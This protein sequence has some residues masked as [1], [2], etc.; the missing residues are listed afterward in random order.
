VNAKLALSMALLVCFE[1]ALGEQKEYDGSQFHSDLSSESGAYSDG[2]TLGFING[3]SS[4]GSG[5]LW[6]FPGNVSIGQIR[7]VVKTFVDDHPEYW[8]ETALNLVV[9]ALQS[10]WPCKT[11]GEAKRR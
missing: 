8:N 2:L 11:H 10:T 1:P 3:V 6:C 9:R 7:A 4:T 5:D